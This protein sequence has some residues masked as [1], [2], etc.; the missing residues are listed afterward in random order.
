[1]GHNHAR[2]D[3]APAPPH[4]GTLW[5]ARMLPGCPGAAGKIRVQY[6]RPYP[7]QHN[8]IHPLRGG[9]RAP[10]AAHSRLA[11]LVPARL[12]NPRREAHLEC[13]YTSASPDHGREHRR[14]PKSTY[15]AN[16]SE[17]RK[18]QRTRIDENGYRSLRRDSRP[19]T[20]IPAR[21]DGFELAGRFSVA[22]GG[23]ALCR[24][25]WPSGRGRV[26]CH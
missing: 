12:R 23:S 2:L 11:A 9:R 7:R 15:W 26:V 8:L 24:S 3:A 22:D 1:M 17:T 5:P 4:S 21:F 13:R 25:S 18:P 20:R 19:V 6:H 16:I 14:P 10:P